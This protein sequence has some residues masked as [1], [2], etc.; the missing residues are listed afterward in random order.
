MMYRGDSLDSSSSAA[1]SE[2][3]LTD[4]NGSSSSSIEEDF[5]EEDEDEESYQIREGI[6]ATYLAAKEKENAI[7]RNASQHDRM[8]DMHRIHPGMT[9]SQSTYAA[10]QQTLPQTQLPRLPQQAG[11]IRNSRSSSN[12]L[13]RMLS[14]AH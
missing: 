13:S 1:T 12:L 11:P 9:K 4:D 5:D 8:A 3:E 2:A 14:S 6:S 7:P 10:S